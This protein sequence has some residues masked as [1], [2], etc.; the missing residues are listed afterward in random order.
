MIRAG[1]FWLAA[2][3]LAA[4][5]VGM[6]ALTILRGRFLRRPHQTADITPPVSVIIAAHNE[7]AVIGERIE[8]LL[9]LD[10]PRYEL[11]F[12]VASAADPVVALVRSLIAEHPDVPARILV[13]DERISANPKLN[14]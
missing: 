7:V 3:I 5:Y 6:P 10:Y 9:A 2:A 13:G 12:C 8:N 11:I 1:I 4:T 14:N